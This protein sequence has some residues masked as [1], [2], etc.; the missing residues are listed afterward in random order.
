[1]FTKKF[2]KLFPPP[3]FLNIPYAGLDIS[4]NAI[5]CVEY[6]EGLRGLVL[7]KFGS[8]KLEPGIV[9][10]GHIKKEKELIDAVSALARELKINTVKVSLPEERMYLFKTEVATTDEDQIRRNIEFKLEENV[11]LPAS[12]ALFFF[13]LIP[14][15]NVQDIFASVSV[16]PRELVNSYLNVVRSSGLDVISFEIQA[17]A[18]ARSVVPNDSLETQIIVHNMNN[19]IGV[20]IVCGNVVCFTSTLTIETTADTNF[21]QRELKRVY[22]YWNEHGKGKPINKIILSGQDA[23]KISNDSKISPDPKISIEIANVWQNAFSHD[24][25]VP[26][27]PFEESL[28]YVVAAGLALP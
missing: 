2:F 21:L 13:D 10:S 17:K 14:D 28:E 7:H 11:P 20:Y 6:S 1:M 9:D 23:L 12:E 15:K 26:A 4:D 18:I 22:T 27:I 3:K 19:K 5:H 16:A 25:Y 24:H 8:K